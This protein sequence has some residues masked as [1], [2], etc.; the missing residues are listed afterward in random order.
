[1]ERS[2]F[3]V[4][5]VPISKGSVGNII[6]NL[7]PVPKMPRPAD[8]GPKYPKAAAT[9]SA[10]K[11]VRSAQAANG[12]GAVG[13]ARAGGKA[14]ARDARNTKRAFGDYLKG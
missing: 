8:M 4:E 10:V 9:K 7:K 12:G 6:G 2:A 1:M 14:V 13:L 5:H 3:G 11:T